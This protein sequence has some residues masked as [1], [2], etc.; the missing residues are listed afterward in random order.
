MVDTLLPELAREIAER[1][2]VLCFD[3]FHVHDVA[4]AM[5]LMRLFTSLLDRGVAVVAT[6]NY[7]PD[8]LYAGGLQREL[9]LPFIALLK[10]RLEVIH[11]DGGEDYR[12]RCL[13]AEGTY[14][15]PLGGGTRHK[16]DEVFAHLTDQ[17]APHDE[18]LTVKG[19]E[20]RVPVVAKGAA[21]LS[22]AELCEQP[23]GAE[24]FLTL[25]R[26]YHTLF[27]DDVP[28]LGSHRRDEAKRLMTLVD[29]LYDTGTRLVVTAAAPPDQL[30]Q[31]DD[32]AFDFRRTTSR[33]LEMQSE[34]YLRRMR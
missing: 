5:I 14:F 20:I 34:G 33:L 4:D 22:F 19:R 12:A 11:L 30:Y 28:K 26:T 32:H 25:A 16:A 15:W 24:D 1:N 10:E 13:Q 3:E 21:R 17:A 18:V 29:T 7:R 31:G 9:F 6:S 27:L 23:H 8:D 2:K